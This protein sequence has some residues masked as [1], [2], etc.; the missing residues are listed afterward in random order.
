MLHFSY[1]AHFTNFGAFFPR[2]PFLFVT[3]LNTLR[4]TQQMKSLFLKGGKSND[5]LL[6]Y[7]TSIGSWNGSTCG[8]TNNFLII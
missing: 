6:S 5:C 3:L 4:L 1:V 7:L 8:V 2:L